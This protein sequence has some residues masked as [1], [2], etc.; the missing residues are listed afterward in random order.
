MTLVGFASA[1]RL[2]YL[3]NLFR[4][5]AFFHCVMAEKTVAELQADVTQLFSGIMEA[6]FRNA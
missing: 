5:L 1:Q 2:C 3:R 6:R 4:A